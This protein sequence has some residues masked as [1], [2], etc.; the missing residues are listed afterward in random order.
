MVHYLGGWSG[1]M[2]SAKEFQATVS[3]EGHCTP[4]WATAQDP[5]WGAGGKVK[6][7]IDLS[8][9]S[10]RAVS[11]ARLSWIHLYALEDN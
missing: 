4:D 5:A 8:F 1:K 9:H 10:A 3:Y 11:N 2:A 7:I 6:Q